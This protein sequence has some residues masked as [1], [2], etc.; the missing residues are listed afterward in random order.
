MNKGGFE[1]EGR[2]NLRDRPLR[3][4]NSEEKEFDSDDI[5]GLTQ[6]Q[7]TDKS[8]NK[9]KDDSADAQGKP[10]EGFDKLKHKK[11]KEGDFQTENMEH[12]KDQIKHSGRNVQDAATGKPLTP[13]PRDIDP[14]APKK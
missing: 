11:E 9:S 2:E 10:A 7:S 1:E 3:K 8:S 12:L 14:K 5:Q 13:K 4:L 6:S